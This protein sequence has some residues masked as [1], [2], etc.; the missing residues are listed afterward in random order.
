MAIKQDKFKRLTEFQKQVIN[1]I[2]KNFKESY[3]FTIK[4]EKTMYDPDWVEDSWK[5]WK[6]IMPEVCEVYFGGEFL[7]DVN[8]KMQPTEALALINLTLINKFRGTK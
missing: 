7:C 2:D 1:M 6:G 3:R 5:Q 4:A 8:Q